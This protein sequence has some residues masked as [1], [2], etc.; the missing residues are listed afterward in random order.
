MELTE[1][2]AP[3]RVVLDIRARDKTHLIAD[4]SRLA[5]NQVA[6]ISAAT[7]E[8]ALQA[9]ERLGSTGLGSG[10][11]LPHARIEGLT[12][13]LGL[14]VRLVRPIEFEAIDG[15]PVDLVFLLLIPAGAGDYVSALAAVSRR[16]RDGGFVSRLRKAPNPAVAFSLLTEH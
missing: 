5:A 3:A 6:P 9:R 12:Q 14:F 2:I 15:N 16:F 11:A 10:F 8:D 7:I 13:F 1:L 4:L